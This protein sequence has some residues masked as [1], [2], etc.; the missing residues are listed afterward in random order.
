MDAVDHAIEKLK[1]DSW[2]G[3]TVGDPLVPSKFPWRLDDEKLVY[4]FYEKTLKVGINT[5]VSIRV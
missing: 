1:P 2:K 3:Y 4:P 5:V